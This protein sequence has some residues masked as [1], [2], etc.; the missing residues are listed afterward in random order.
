MDFGGFAEVMIR[1]SIVVPIWNRVEYLFGCLDSIPTAH[2]VEIIVVDDGSDVDVEKVCRCRPDYDRLRFIRQEH[3]GVLAARRHGCEKARGEYVWFVDSDDEVKAIPHIPKADMIRYKQNYG[4]MC[5]GDKIYRRELA[6]R[7]FDEIGDL[8]LNHCEDGIFYLIAKKKA[9]TII[10]SDESIYRYVHRGDSASG[11]FNPNVISERELLVDWCV[12]LDEHA[13][14]SMLSKDAFVA[15]ACSLC[16]WPSTWKQL[17][18]TCRSLIK[19][20]LSADGMDEIQNDSYAKKM[21][22][23]M[24]H[25]LCVLIY[26][27]LK[28]ML[29]NY[30]NIEVI[31]LYK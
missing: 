23:A 18:Q 19:S 3:Q 13:D 16:K 29:N 24:R 12:K 9:A 26:R 31:N 6:L 10:D 27:L 5:I 21:L 22:F 17:E 28:R 20:R 25:P 7:V 15:I 14:R 2:D 11:R 1:I 8:K 4:W 30:E